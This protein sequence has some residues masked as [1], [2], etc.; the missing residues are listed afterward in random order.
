INKL[1]GRPGINMP[2]LQI[3]GGMPA[4]NGQVYDD[5]NRDPDVPAIIWEIRR[6]RRVELMAEGF[7]QWDLKRWKQ[8]DNADYYKNKDLNRGAWV[9]FSDYPTSEDVKV[10]DALTLTGTNKGYIVPAPNQVSWRRV[11]P[12]DYLGPIPLNQIQL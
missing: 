12:R 8:L 1:R 6:E 7:R 4:V 10:R 9:D 5:P 11:K 2:H 3:M